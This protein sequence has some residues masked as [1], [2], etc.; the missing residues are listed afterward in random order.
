VAKWYASKRG[1]DRAVSDRDLAYL[2]DLIRDPDMLPELREQLADAILGLLTGQTKRPAHRPKREATIR[3]TEGI[4]ERVW[5]LR[6]F[7]GWK[8]VT[9]AVKRVSEELGCS[10]KKVWNAWR[11]FDLLKHEMHHEK[12]SFD[13]M[14]NAAHEARLEEAA[15]WLAE[16]EGAREFSDEEVEAAAKQ[17]DEQWAEHDGY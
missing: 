4:G 13:A 12:A 7:E 3:E 5:R 8:K 15:A 6:R 9:S 14:L 10:E 2:T 16:N 17:L 11:D 1:I